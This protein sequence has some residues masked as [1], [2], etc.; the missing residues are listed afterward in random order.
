MDRERESAILTVDELAEYLK[1]HRTTIY[2][3]VKAR[4]LPALRISAPTGGSTESTSTNGESLKRS[5]KRDEETSRAM[6]W[7]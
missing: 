5:A 1:V 2:R 3:L 4:K 6:R 7:G